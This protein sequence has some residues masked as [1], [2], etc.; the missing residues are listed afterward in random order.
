VLVSGVVTWRGKRAVDLALSSV[1]AVVL[2]PVAAVV[3]AFVRLDAGTPVLFRQRRVGQ[4][5]EEFV[6]LKFRT[7][8]NDAVR[9]GVEQ[10]VSDDPYGVVA[11]DPRF[12]RSGAFLRRTSLDELPQLVNVIRGEMSLVG[13][14]PDIPEQVRY[15]SESDRDRLRGRPGI[16]GLAQVLGRDEIDWPA[17]IRLDRE[18][19]SRISWRLD[20][21][22]LANTVK[23]VFRKDPQPLFDEWNAGKRAADESGSPQSRG[24]R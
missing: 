22:I 8:V 14:R 2:A 5:G 20:L 13:P 12:T 17:R 9:V 3:A 11:N 4:G 23:E 19:L 16:T 15:Y 6:M 10:G 7:M 1:L 21:W 24:S 18:Y